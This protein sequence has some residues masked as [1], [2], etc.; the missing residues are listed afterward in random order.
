MLSD[1][2]LKP[3]TP[4]QLN[5]NR[6]ILTGALHV[7]L[8]S[9]TWPRDPTDL[10]SVTRMRGGTTLLD[11][12]GSAEELADDEGMITLTFLTPEGEESIDLILA[13]VMR[14]APIACIWNLVSFTQ[15][16]EFFAVQKMG[17]AISEEEPGEQLL[18]DWILI[19]AF[20]TEATGGEG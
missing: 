15:G 12:E 14:A 3:V 4:A 19:A 17:Q 1:Y 7:A 11:V 2:C 20:G 5:V 16:V 8:S 18:R 6:A 10:F 9:D 13:D